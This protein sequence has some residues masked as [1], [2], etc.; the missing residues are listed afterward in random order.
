MHSSALFGATEKPIAMADKQPGILWC[1]R[2]SSGKRTLFIRRLG[3]RLQVAGA[4]TQLC[5]IGR[6]GDPGPVVPEAGGSSSTKNRQDSVSS[7]KP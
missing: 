2:R 7:S 1:F 5:Q 3:R 4:A 6:V